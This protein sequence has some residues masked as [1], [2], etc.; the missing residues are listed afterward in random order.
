MFRFPHF[1]SKSGLKFGSQ[2]EK[3]FIIHILGCSFPHGE[4]ETLHFPHFLH[5]SAVVCLTLEEKCF[6]FPIL[7]TFVLKFGSWWRQNVSSSPFWV[8]IWA[9]VWLTVAEKHFVFHILSPFGL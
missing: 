4:G 3:H 7:C 8:Q 2:E 1:G 9:E 6:V 5:I